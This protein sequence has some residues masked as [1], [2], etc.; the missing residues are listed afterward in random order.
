MIE[1]DEMR[2]LFQAET[3]EH[4]QALEQGLLHLQADPTDEAVLDETFRAAHGL[5]G[6]AR[7]LQVGK[8]EIIAHR[9]EDVLR[10]VKNGQIVLLPETADRL[11][12]ALDAIREFCQEAI[13][14]E[15]ATTDLE[16]VIKQ[17]EEHGS[18]GLVADSDGADSE[19]GDGK[20]IQPAADQP[21]T[22]RDVQTASSAPANVN[23]DKSNQPRLILLVEDSIVTRTQ[24]KR[25]LEA[26]G[27]EVIT[28][29]DGLDALIKLNTRA[30]DAVISDVEMPNLSGLDFTEKVR[31]IEQHK[32]LPIILVTSLATDE[33]RKR[34]MDVGADAYLTKPGF[35]QT[36][37]L[38]TLKRFI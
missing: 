15:R 20:E 25:I 26:A 24:E 34:G 19:F 5:K 33:D 10:K 30:F 12:Q 21:R 37:F 9:F 7:M 2:G 4:L 22:K 27:Y 35:D 14:G 31:Q 36:V 32:N 8:V 23:E 11:Y 28:A 17:L 13:T 3:R 16:G 6:A 29:V 1:D 18:P 38:Q